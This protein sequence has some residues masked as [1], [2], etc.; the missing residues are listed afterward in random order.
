MAIGR[1]VPP[2]V[3]VVGAVERINERKK[4]DT[5]LLWGWSI[6]VEQEHGGRVEVTFFKRDNEV[7][8]VPAHG[9]RVALECEVRESNQYGAQLNFHADAAALLDALAAV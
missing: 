6:T 8:P 9:E 2:R 3:I 7:T 5:G 1:A 4:A